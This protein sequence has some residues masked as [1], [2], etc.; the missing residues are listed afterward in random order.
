MLLHGNDGG[1]AKM[2]RLFAAAIALLICSVIPVLA[3]VTLKEQWSLTSVS[4]QPEAKGMYCS[5]EYAYVG[6]GGPSG[7]IEKV[8]LKDGSV[9]WSQKTETYQPSYPV[10]NGKVVVFGTCYKPKI[11]ALD[12]QTGK[13]LWELATGQ[14]NMAAARFSGDLVF[15]ASYD[16]FIYAIEWATGK[17]RWKTDLGVSIWSRPWVEGNQVLV[18]CFYGYL[19]FLDKSTGVVMKKIDCGGT[20]WS[21][22]IV[23]NGLVFLTAGTVPYGHGDTELVEGMGTR[24]LVIDPKKGTII[25][26]FKS[27]RKRMPFSDRFVIDGRRVLFFDW[28]T[29]RSY[30]TK[31]RELAWSLEAPQVQPAP[32]LSD[33]K[34]IL[35]LNSTGVEGQHQS[36]LL[37]V[38]SK[39]GKVIQEQDTGGV[40]S[41]LQNYVQCGDMVILTDTMQAFKIVQNGPAPEVTSYIGP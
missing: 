35:A 30:D 6:S 12:D 33:G 19:Y 16:H 37:V 41:N 10:S 17:M 28:R 31:R 13:P 36:K 34:V 5:D 15:I 23:A 1:N 9:I 7:V 2:K 26:E 20:I 39:T 11:V 38:D 40:G 8:R 18:G 27:E 32:I 29:V 14:Q 22:P 24:M 3:E 4:H 21:S 25:N